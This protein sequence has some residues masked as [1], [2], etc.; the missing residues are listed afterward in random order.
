MQHEG[1]IYIVDDDPATRESLQALLDSMGV[2]I[3]TYES[4]EDFLAA[5]DRERP[6]CLIS[7]LRM[8]GM[9]G[10]EL[11]QRLNEL[12]IKLPTIIMTAFADVPVAVKAMQEGAV[13][14]L[15]KPCPDQ[16]IWEVVQKALRISYD[17]E[18]KRKSVEDIRERLS[19][20]TEQERAVLDMVVEGVPNKAIARRQQVSIRTVETRRRN[21]FQKMGVN[22]VALLVQKIMQLKD[23]E[24][25]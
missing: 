1:I 5:F 14:L 4:A 16:T 18:D 23:G 8:I 21:V 2:E 11:Q 15:E 20:L 3:R 7:D 25:E 12:G 6:G 19:Q 9:S 10:V 24:E 22:T 13:M 17:R